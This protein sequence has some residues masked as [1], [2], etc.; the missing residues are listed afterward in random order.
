MALGNVPKLHG[1]VGILAA[2]CALPVG[3]GDEFEGCEASR[4]C[5]L[6]LAIRTPTSAPMSSCRAT[7]A[8]CLTALSSSF[9]DCSDAR[10]DGGAHSGRNHGRLPA[11]GCT[12]P[13]S[14]STESGSQPA[15][16]ATASTTLS[17]AN[18]PVSHSVFGTSS[19]DVVYV[20]SLSAHLNPSSKTETGARPTGQFAGFAVRARTRGSLSPA[21]RAPRPHRT[22]SHHAW[23]RDGERH[24]A[25]RARRTRRHRANRSRSH[26]GA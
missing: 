1:L 14:R 20:E 8:A 19:R 5:P 6:G 3:C 26:S 18:A 11:T 13:T 22:R 17:A 23:P 25:P 4:T 16:T 24:H 15:R 10:T 9:C 7:S 2:V 12:W 21:H